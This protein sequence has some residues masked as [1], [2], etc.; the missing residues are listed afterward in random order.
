[1]RGG[2]WVE[3]IQLRQTLRV[4]LVGLAFE[5][6][7]LPGLAGGVGDQAAD[8]AF[9]TQIVDPA[10]QQ[11]GLDDDHG[12]PFPG[13]QSLHFATCR[14]PAGEAEGARGLVVHAGDALVFAEVDGENGAR[15][16]RLGN[17][18]HAAT[19]SWGWWGLIAW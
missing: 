9:G 14:L 19:S 7:E 10:G 18:V 13:Q 2:T 12:G 5:V 3:P 4:V 1:G 6:L 17:G 11:A 16:R 15:G 8:A